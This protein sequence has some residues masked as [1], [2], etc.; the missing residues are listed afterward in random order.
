MYVLASSVP[1]CA[2]FWLY[3]QHVH[4]RHNCKHVSFLV[5][6][7]NYRLLL[8]LNYI[9][10]TLFGSLADS[11]CFYLPWHPRRNRSTY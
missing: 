11:E 3:R 1:P 9:Y 6:H 4:H 7:L 10:H 5:V 8:Q 2:R